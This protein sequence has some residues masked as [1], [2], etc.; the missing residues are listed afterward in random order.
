MEVAEYATLK[1]AAAARGKLVGLL[2][3][4]AACCVAVGAAFPLTRPGDLWL[5]AV[6]LLCAVVAFRC[7]PLHWKD[8]GVEIAISTCTTL[9]LRIGMEHVY[10]LAPRIASMCWLCF[11]ALGNDHTSWS[12]RGTLMLTGVDGVVAIACV[13]VKALLWEGASVIAAAGF[14]L[15]RHGADAW[16]RRLVAVSLL[17]LVFLVLRFTLLSVW[18]AQT[19]SVMTATEVA[20]LRLFWSAEIDVPSLLAASLVIAWSATGGLERRQP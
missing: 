5:A 11:V 19:P 8:V 18:F 13:P 10:D 4:A 12:D 6:A 3:G 9:L 1:A 14:T 7:T 15:R 17:W 20:R 16:R 2:A